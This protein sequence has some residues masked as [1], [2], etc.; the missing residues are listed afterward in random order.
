MT[1]ERRQ[2]YPQILER[3]AGIEE[4]LDSHIRNNEKILTKHEHAIFGNGKDGLSIQTD[5]LIESDKNRKS[6]R[7]A[8]VAANAGWIGKVLYDFF[9]KKP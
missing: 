3:L 7:L 5:R 1:V 8:V 6:W 9:T 4:K 2:D